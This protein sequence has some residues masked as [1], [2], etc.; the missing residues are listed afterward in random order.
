[1]QDGIFISVNEGLNSWLRKQMRGKEVA[2]M[3]D[4]IKASMSVRDLE[5]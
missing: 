4:V 5:I 3:G 1:M 2:S